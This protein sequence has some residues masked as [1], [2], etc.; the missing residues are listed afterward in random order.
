MGS[1]DQTIHIFAS[2]LGL[3]LLI[4]ECKLQKLNEVYNYNKCPKRKWKESCLEL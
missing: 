2:E 1:M 4:F 3:D